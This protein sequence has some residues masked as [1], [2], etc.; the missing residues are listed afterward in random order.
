MLTCRD[1]LQATHVPVNGTKATKY[2]VALVLTD[3]ITGVNKD[4]AKLLANRIMTRCYGS[5]RTRLGECIDLM[6]VDPTRAIRKLQGTYK[7]LDD[8]IN[9]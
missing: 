6:R 1:D 9:S 3:S 4:C 5:L 7:E 2:T 8:E